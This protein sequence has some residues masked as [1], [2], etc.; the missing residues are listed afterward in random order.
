VHYVQKAGTCSWADTRY[1]EWAA[2]FASR[3]LEAADKGCETGMA[4][5]EMK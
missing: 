5:I 1:G 3:N 2:D 4:P